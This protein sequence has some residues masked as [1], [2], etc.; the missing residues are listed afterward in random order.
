[1][2]GSPG[3]TLAFASCARRR[4]VEFHSPQGPDPRA[5]VPHIVGP[6]Y[7]K[8]QLHSRAGCRRKGSSSRCS[9]HVDQR[10]QFATLQLLRPAVVGLE[11]LQ[12]LRAAEGWIRRPCG[13]M[14]HEAEAP[15]P[16]PPRCMFA[17]SAGP[18]FARWRA[19]VS[20]QRSGRFVVHQAMEAACGG[21][22]QLCARLWAG[23]RTSRRGSVACRDS[24]AASLLFSTCLHARKAFKAVAA[25]PITTPSLH[26][27]ML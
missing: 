7:A 6:V 20:R 17:A 24:I 2:I 15:P 22:A 3:S 16:L 1:M 4:R 27:V 9:R 25:A 5:D 10:R 23:L 11:K 26:P 8:P 18:R 21:H 19:P 13:C 12:Q 14:M